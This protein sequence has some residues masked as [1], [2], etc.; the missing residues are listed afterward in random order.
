MYADGIFHK[1][2][3]EELNRVLLL[4]LQYFNLKDH[5]VDKT[6]MNVTDEK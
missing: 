6:E 4:Y 3:V 5:I 2:D 1:K